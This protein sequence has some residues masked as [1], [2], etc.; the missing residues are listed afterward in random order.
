MRAELYVKPLLLLTALG[1]G[2]ARADAVPPR[3]LRVC[4][5]PN[6]LPFSDRKERGLENALAELLAKDLGATLRYTWW[7]QRRGAVRSTLTAGECD[8][9]MG[10][11]TSLESLATTA[12]YYTSSY[13]FL[14]RRSRGLGITSFDDPRLRTLRVGVQLVGDDYAN[15]PPVHALSRRGISDNVRGYSV[16]GDYG[17]DVPA[18]AIVRA[19]QR[20]EVDVALVWGPLA[21]Y[22]AREPSNDLV[23]A[24]VPDHEASLPMR[25][26]ISMGTRRRDEA[27]RSEV[28]AF[29]TRRQSEIDA[30]LRRY[31][32]PRP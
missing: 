14:S 16:L 30:L 5:D 32:V 1:L 19:V 26:A 27:L 3:V 18:A 17:G 29:I 31:G 10:V 12:P 20:G 13:V 2:S 23:V 21:G 24:L 25:F 28:D 4:A 8:V 11:P 7:A 15:T 22:F 6:N 9:M